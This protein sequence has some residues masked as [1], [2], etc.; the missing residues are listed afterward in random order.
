LSE[1]P[2]KGISAPLEYANKSGGSLCLLP[3]LLI[4]ELQAK[5][6]LTFRFSKGKTAKITMTFHETTKITTMFRKLQK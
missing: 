5:T 4:V 3:G 6:F 2:W 1:T